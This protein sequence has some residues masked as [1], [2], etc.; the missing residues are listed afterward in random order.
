[1][2]RIFLA[3]VLLVFALATFGS[4]I[5]IS[6]EMDALFPDAQIKVPSLDDT[7]S[8]EVVVTLSHVDPKKRNAVA[9]SLAADLA[10]DP[11]VEEIR[12]SAGAPSE[13]F[14][15]WI[16][17]NRFH[18]APPEA[19][20]FESTRMAARLEEAVEYFS[21]INSMI[22]GD[23]FLL[24]PTGSY[25]R[26][27]QA[28][29]ESG[30]DILTDILTEQDGVWQSFDQTAAV[31][32]LRLTDQPFNA[33]EIQALATSI[34]SL[35]AKEGVTA[36]ILGLRIIAAETTLFNT[37]V[38]MRASILA[39]MLLLCWL[40]WS[41][42][43]VAAAFLAF[44]PVALGLTAAFIA[45]S[46]IFGAVHIVAVAF[47]GVLLGLALD[48]PIHAMGHP[49]HLRTKAHR[50]IFLGAL[51]TGI[52]FLAM[53][54]SQ[55]PAL[56]QTGV[57]ILVGLT[58]SALATIIVPNPRNVNVRGLSLHNITFR[59]PAKAVIEY[60]LAGLGVVA[61]MAFSKEAPI[62]LFE[63]PQ[64]IRSE[65]QEMAVKLNLPSSKFAIDVQG[66]TLTAL[67]QHEAQLALKLDREIEKG[68]LKSYKMLA[69][70]LPSN[71]PS[72]VN[73]STFHTNAQA[74]L[75]Q[76][77]MSVDYAQ[78]QLEAYGQALQTPTINQKDLASFPETAELAKRITITTD[79]WY[80]RVQ[81]TLPTGTAQ[82]NFTI[83]LPG[84]E[85]IDL[86]APLRTSMTNLKTRISFWLLIG[87]ICGLGV[88]ALGL[89]SWSQ[90]L[91]I[92]RTSCAVLGASACLLI[93]LYG[94]L[95]LFH[96]VAMALVLGI[97]VD[98]SI[99]LAG[100]KSEGVSADISATS[101]F[102]C[103]IST[104]I[105]F[106][107]LAFS[108]VQILHQIGT[109]VVIGLLLMLFLTLAKSGSIEE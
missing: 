80:E 6:T 90:T 72:L 101:I 49:G 1:M 81:V 69:Q 77:D 98:Y 83:D 85:M 33:T 23:R 70:L 65:I 2:K 54:G 8:R 57:F 7:A 28:L 107:V 79:G 21:N 46:L 108:E 93:I 63:P 109:T 92:F 99:I 9:R 86:L 67:L 29:E 16:W 102:I 87:L 26:L 64:H 37:G 31:L 82:P 100:L 97:G 89:K 73:P 43:S 59:L 104:L 42:R 62:T 55:V 11:L 13:A 106:I 12:F 58:V 52:S 24:D 75:A 105:A 61:I 96:I 15:T 47:G 44:L 76:V 48:Y 74:A 41:L 95:S 94:S 30:A 22:H 25:Y 38:S 51:T 68:N 36:H 45:V 5:E 60:T 71:I 34:R 39:A 20:D 103:A 91:R 18:L 4:K 56:V 84:A 35:S 40:I 17:D 53:V 78:Q 19:A 66:D 88:L 27:T 14:Q 50:L 3:V 32:H 10:A